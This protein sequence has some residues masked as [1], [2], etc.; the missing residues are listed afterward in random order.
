MAVRAKHGRPIPT[1]EKRRMNRYLTSE[2]C[3]RCG[4]WSGEM[5][6]FCNGC[7]IEASEWKPLMEVS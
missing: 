1:R 6:L 5:A 7:R 4:H 2:D 3:C